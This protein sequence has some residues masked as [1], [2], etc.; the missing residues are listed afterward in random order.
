M[1]FIDMNMIPSQQAQPKRSWA[2][3]RTSRKQCRATQ[4]HPR[5][6]RLFPGEPVAI[7]TEMVNHSIHKGKKYKRV[8]RVSVTNMSG[9][10]VLDTFCY[11]P[12]QVG[13]TISFDLPIFGVEYGDI[14]PE[15]GAQ[16]IADIVLWLTKICKDRPVVMH[17]V[18]S[19]WNA[20]GEH[21]ADI[22]GRSD[23]IDTQSR[24]L[25]G[26][27]NLPSLTLEHL[28]KDIQGIFHS[29]V[30]DA[31]ATGELWVLATGYDR[32]A[33]FAAY[34][35]DGEMPAE[36]LHKVYKA[37]LKKRPQQ[38]VI[39][40]TIIP[41]APAEYLEAK[42]TAE[43]PYPSLTVKSN[44]TK[45]LGSSGQA[46]QTTVLQPQKSTWASIAAK[47]K[48]Q[49]ATWTRF[50]ANSKAAKNPRINEQW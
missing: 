41:E 29:S 36:E 37:F 12:E 9:E 26:K 35:R 27:R 38:P 2:S 43:P 31:Q 8:G 20:F 7:D 23:M 28:N 42:P 17:D 13:L 44:E 30:E 15:N 14:Q 25:Y 16:P 39:P 21:V 6:D 48:P 19:D 49:T 45:V 11:Y 18:H 40:E 32:D 34:M 33:H 24:S 4:L 47:P 3:L 22:F 10:T 5:Y 50:A 46:S 1:P